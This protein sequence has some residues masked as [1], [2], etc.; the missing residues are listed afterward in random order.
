MF[1]VRGE[2]VSF[3]GL[4]ASAGNGWQGRLPFLFHNRSVVG[5][6]NSSWKG[7]LSSRRLGNARIGV[8]N[9]HNARGWST[10]SLYSS[11]LFSVCRGLSSRTGDSEIKTVPA[12]PSPERR[13]LPSYKSAHATAATKK[14]AGVSVADLAAGLRRSSCSDDTGP[15]P[16]RDLSPLQKRQLLMK[17][18]ATF[19]L[20]PQAVRRV[21]YLIEQYKMKQS[22]RNDKPEGSE[23][24]DNSTQKSAGAAE[25]PSVDVE[26][27]DG[28]RIGVRRRGCSG[29]SYTVNYHFSNAL[30]SKSPGPTKPQEKKVWSPLEE[31][32]VVEQ[33]GLKVVVA[34]DA[35]F[36]VIGTVMDYVVLNVEEKFVF[37]NPNKKY[38]CGCEESFMP[39]D[40]ED[41]EEE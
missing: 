2:R 38:S 16:P 10:A 40:S 36:Y 34:A 29:Y 24:K 37:R 4:K 5:S 1:A 14:P 21:R 26:V 33:E 12:S 11:S 7:T 27:P 23:E 35:L 9:D 3:C 6:L 22:T 8:C 18:K 31:D 41:M 20:T 25:N 13:V 30:S 19:V 17:N 32:T 15:V 28:I 39:F